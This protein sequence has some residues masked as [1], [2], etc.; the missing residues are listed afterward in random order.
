MDR[1]EFVFLLPVWNSQSRRRR[2]EAS[3]ILV[4]VEAESGGQEWGDC[5]WCSLPCPFVNVHGGPW[6]AI[7][8]P[9]VPSPCGIV[10]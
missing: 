5:L 4:R 6:L 7:R 3:R 2:G 1:T 10:W 9:G 8:C